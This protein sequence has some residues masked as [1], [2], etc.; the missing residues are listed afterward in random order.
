MTFSDIQKWIL[1]REC[2]RYI[3]C[4]T[5]QIILFFI[6]EDFYVCARVCGCVYVYGCE[7]VCGC[8]SVEMCVWMYVWMDACGFVVMD[9]CECA[10]G[11]VRG[12]VWMYVWIFFSEL[13]RKKVK[14]G[15]I[16]FGFL[17]LWHIELCGLPKYEVHTISFQTFFV[18]AL[19]LIVHTRN[20]NPPS[21]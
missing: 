14:F 6:K 7:D 19:L 13:K 9:V 21:K 12:C 8:V 18:W 1:C 11:C 17:V 3:L 2:S 5:D 16:W 4:L 15:L 10:C 20:S